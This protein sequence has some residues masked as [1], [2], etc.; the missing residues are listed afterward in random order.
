VPLSPDI[1]IAKLDIKLQI[2]TFSRP[3]TQESLSWAF[4]TPNN[5][6]EAIS[7]FEFIKFRIAR[8]QNSSPTS[9]YDVIDQFSKKAR[10]IMHKMA[11]LQTEV[12]ELQKA[13]TLIS[14]RR[15]AKKTRVRLEKSFNSQNVQDLQD[16]KDVAQQ[17]QQEMRENGAKS[18]R[19]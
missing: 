19:G 14:K 12:A 18:N 10:N 3:L 13:N 5:P 2:P 8:H 9:I 4:R 11:L 7:Q 16:Q 15:R 6:I 17:I 1:V